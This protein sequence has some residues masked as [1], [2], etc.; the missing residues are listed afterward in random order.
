MVQETF[1]AIVDG[2]VVAIKKA[3][4]D[5]EARRSKEGADETK[6]RIWFGNT[7]VKGAHINREYCM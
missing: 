1:D 2:T 4:E 7:T 6:N 3:H 5:Y